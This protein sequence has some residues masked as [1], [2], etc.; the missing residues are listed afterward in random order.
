MP[1]KPDIVALNGRITRCQRCPRLIE[2]CRQVAAEKTARYRDKPYWGKPVPNLLPPDP[3]GARGAR[4]LIVGLAPG[5]HG[6]NRTGRMFTGDRSGDFLFSAMHRAGL[7]NQPDSVGEGDG[8]ELIDT[9][10]T[11]AGHC[12]PP[13]NKP[14]AEELDACSG[15]L[16]QTYDLLPDLRVVI[17]LGGIAHRAMLKLYRGRGLVDR[18]SRYPFGHGAWHGFDNAPELVCCYHPSQQN[19]FTGRLTPDMLFEVL[20][21]A[22]EYAVK[23]EQS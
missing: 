18:I 23:A 7:C 1:R 3:M 6:A 2:H 12:A 14:T 19:T 21:K 4:L 13:G 22:R 15:Y 8:L 9:V 5:A 16:D 17:S 10:V 20:N 11:G